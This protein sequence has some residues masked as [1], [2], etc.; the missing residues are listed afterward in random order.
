MKQ[1]K[2]VKFNFRY[3]LIM[4]VTYVTLNHIALM[5]EIIKNNCG[6]I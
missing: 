4:Y 1:N 6:P 2:R 5:R 3:I